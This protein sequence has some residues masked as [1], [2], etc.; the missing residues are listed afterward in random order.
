MKTCR[1]CKTGKAKSFLKKDDGYDGFCN[2]KTCYTIYKKSR[3]YN[4][5]WQETKSLMDRKS[6]GICE[7]CNKT[8]LTQS[9]LLVD[10]CA[11]TLRIRGVT[12]MS[13]NINVK[14]YINGRNANT[15]AQH[16][17]DWAE[18]TQ[19]K[20]MNPLYVEKEE[21]RISKMGPSHHDKLEA[22]KEKYERIQ[23]HE[24]EECLKS[25]WKPEE[26]V[27][28]SA[29]EKDDILSSLLKR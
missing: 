10:V 8:K 16:I 14:N 22:N 18:R 27:S 13:C 21:Y 1:S 17:L 29:V 5:H 20:T 7:C 26:E 12:C 28:L 6:N 23:R 2:K 9:Q 25:D 11:K 24:W 15:P 3:Q 4:T 19:Y